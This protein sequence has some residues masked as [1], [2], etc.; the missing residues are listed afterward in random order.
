M[1]EVVLTG[2]GVWLV[3]GLSKEEQADLGQIG[4]CPGAGQPSVGAF[5]CCL[6]PLSQVLLEKKRGC[7][8]LSTSAASDFVQGFPL[9]L[10]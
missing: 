3:V 9:A 5:H 8:E 6:R 1:D 2:L 10:H 4:L 7:G